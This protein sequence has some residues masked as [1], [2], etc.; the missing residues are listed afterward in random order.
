MTYKWVD[1]K[2]FKL[3]SVVP[4]TR[5]HLEM[6]GHSWLP[7]G[8]GVYWP[9]VPRCQE[10]ETSCSGQ[11]SQHNKQC[12]LDV[13]GTRTNKR[14]PTNWPLCTPPGPQ[15]K[16]ATGRSLWSSLILKFYL[17]YLEL[18][19][20]PAGQAYGPNLFLSL[21]FKI[22]LQGMDRSQIQAAGYLSSKTL[23]S[24]LAPAWADIGLCQL[25]LGLSIEK[26]WE[27]LKRKKTAVTAHCDCHKLSCVLPRTLLNMDKRA[28]QVVGKQ[29][30]SSVGSGEIPASWYFPFLP[31][32][33]HNAL[34]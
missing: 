8:I 17:M 12:L 7:Q 32:L 30:L 28:S 31:V 24:I 13:N 14:S 22:Y 26:C 34:Q 10:F 33:K 16:E 29:F 18:C 1:C 6:Q 21:H 5:G 4:P 23:G 9:L 19:E 20:A 2:Q 27:S 15:K 3:P 25:I 11:N